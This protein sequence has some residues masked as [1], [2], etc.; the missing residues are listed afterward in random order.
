MSAILE[1]DG[2]EEQG[3]V[4]ILPL[5][6]PQSKAA[7]SGRLISEP[8]WLSEEAAA[9]AF[10]QEKVPA[11]AKKPRDGVK[12][13][14]VAAR[15]R[16]KSA[17]SFRRYVQSDEAGLSATCHSTAGGF[18][19]LATAPAASA[20]AARPRSAGAHGR[21]ISAGAHGR[22]ASAGA[23][24]RPASAASRRGRA[25]RAGSQASQP[26]RL[27]QSWHDVEMS[28]VHTAT[29]MTR[30]EVLAGLL[31]EHAHAMGAQDKKLRYAMLHRGSNQHLE[32]ALLGG[33]PKAVQQLRDQCE[34]ARQQGTAVAKFQHIGQW[35]SSMELRQRKEASQKSRQS[36][37]SALGSSNG[38]GPGSHPANSISSLL[39]ADEL[40][41]TSFVE[42]HEAKPRPFG[43][44]FSA[45]SKVTFAVQNVTGE[46]TLLPEETSE[47]VSQ[48]PD[49][50]PPASNTEHGAEEEQTQLAEPEEQEEA[51]RPLPKGRKTTAF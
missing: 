42:Q 35:V 26:R 20:A 39:E 29:A 49:M 10:K 16:P 11:K 13:L 1:E 28:K 50:E 4:C 37:R 45:P 41:L 18:A 2:A 9:D 5:P 24:S 17:T 25:Q 8:A 7:K 27:P 23:Q 31:L 19:A 36:S 12:R 15:A 34:A 30:C 46:A 51:D 22:P 14:Q 6:V 44:P 21:P 33:A 40:E 47:D 43:R 32:R 3:E 48:L 38:R